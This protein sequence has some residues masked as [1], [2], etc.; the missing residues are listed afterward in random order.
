VQRRSRDFFGRR[1]DSYIQATHRP[2]NCLVFLLPLIVIYELGSLTAH[3]LPLETASPPPERVLA[4]YWIMRLLGLFATVPTY[5][6]GLLLL[7]ILA[8]WHLVS[9][10]RGRFRW[11]A[12][13]GMTAES[14]LF[15]IPLLVLNRLVQT[16][17][18]AGGAGG[19]FGLR[20]QM[21]VAVTAGIYE[22]LIFRLLLVWMLKLLLVEVLELPKTGS[23]VAIV[24]VTAALFAGYHYLGAERFNWTTFLFRT[25]AGVLLGMIYVLRGFGVTVGTHAL[26]DIVVTWW[27]M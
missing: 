2:L 13:L 12:V 17:A 22:E 9:E 4:F 27:M 3:S 6:P 23:M 26:Y 8:L 14:F 16:C 24:L 19:E 11:S 18:L 5:L 10:H 1:K 15:C 25:A 20:E 7:V 21:V